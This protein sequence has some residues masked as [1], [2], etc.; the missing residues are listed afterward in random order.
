MILM[1][2]GTFFTAISQILLKQSADSYDG[3]H[4]ERGGYVLGYDLKEFLVWLEDTPPLLNN[5][6]GKEN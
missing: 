2:A 4:I 1:F 3:T 5:I 6:N